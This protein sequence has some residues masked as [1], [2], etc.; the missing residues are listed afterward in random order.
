M[1]FIGDELLA[2]LKKWAEIRPQSGYFFCT[3]SDGDERESGR[4]LSDSYLRQ[5]LRR[6]S[7]EAGVYVNHNHE[8]KPVSPHILRHT[9]ATWLLESGLNIRKVQQQLGHADL[10]ATMLY[11][12]V[13]DD[14]LAAEIQALG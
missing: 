3:V 1:V 12:H 8:I 14:G 11:T 6:K 13:V 5:V 7:H 9:Y 10:S 2:C 4:P